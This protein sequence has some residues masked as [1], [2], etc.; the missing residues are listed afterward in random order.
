MLGDLARALGELGHAAFWVVAAKAVGLTLALLAGAFALAGWALG[1]G[2]GFAID[3]PFLDPVEI[4]GGVG[5]ALFGAAALVAS[6]FLMLPVAALFIGVFL[7]EIVDAV[8]R[9]SYRDLPPAR[10]VPL[11]TQLRASLGLLG[12][13]ALG[14]TLAL[15]VYLIAAPLA[16]FTF[17]AINGWLLGR[18][19][20][21][22]V[23]LRRM[24]RAQAA[25]LRRRW[26]LSAW[27]IGA[28]IAAALI[29]PIANLFAPLIGVAA[30]THLY[31]R[32]TRLK[33]A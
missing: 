31:H 5:G 2:E 30:A 24:D 25:A 11:A 21:E 33:A 12:A 10:P 29:V 7:D 1:V 6:A 22:T 20:L 17:V 3:L 23:A 15:I 27:G 16:P 9:R 32:A 13:M 8:E 28:A 19:Y 26:R 18:E 14:N 4:G